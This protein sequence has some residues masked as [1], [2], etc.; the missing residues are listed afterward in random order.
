MDPGAAARRP[1]VWKSI[2]SSRFQTR[3][4]SCALN[5]TS[6]VELAAALRTGGLRVT[7]PRLAVLSVVSEGKHVTADRSRSRHE[8]ASG[9]S[10]RKPSMTFSAL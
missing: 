1:E 5:R 3:G 8:S 7:A 10:P 4:L 2:E 9:R 6:R